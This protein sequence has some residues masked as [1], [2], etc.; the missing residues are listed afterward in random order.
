VNRLTIISVSN[1]ST[2]DED[3]TRSLAAPRKAAAPAG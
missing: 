1:W 2:T 3:M